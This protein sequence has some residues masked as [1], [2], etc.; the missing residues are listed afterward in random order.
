MPLKRNGTILT[1][2]Q[3]ELQ[4]QE[5]QD[6]WTFQTGVTEIEQTSTDPVATV[7]WAAQFTAPTGIDLPKGEAKD[8]PQV[9]PLTEENIETNRLVDEGLL[10]EEQREDIP[11]I[12][13]QV[14]PV[15]PQ[16]PTTPETTGIEQVDVELDKLRQEKKEEVENLYDSYNISKGQFEKNKQYYTNFDDTNNVFEGV[17]ADIRQ[18]QQAQGNQDL[19]DEQYGQIAQKYGISLEE[20]KNPTQ[21]FQKLEFTDEWK[22]KFGVESAETQIDK[23]Q[24]DFDRAKEDLNT[25]LEVQ[26]ENLENQINDVRDSL[27]RNVAFA[28]AQGVWSGSFRSSGYNQGLENIKEDGQKTISRLQS[29]LERV[30]SANATNL[31]RLTEN[32]NTAVTEAKADLDSQ[33]ETL[34]FDSGLQLSGLSEKY[35]L[36]SDELTKA[37][38]AINEE[39]GTRSLDVYSKYLSNMRDIQT[40]T[41]ENIDRQ[42]ALEEKIREKTDRRYNELLANNGVLLQNTSLNSLMDNVNRGELTVQR[43]NDIK[44]IITSSI[45][46]TLGQYGIVNQADLNTI[47]SLLQQGQTPSQ[48]VAQMQTMDKFKPKAEEEDIIKVKEWET[49]YDPT[50][51]TFTT[52]PTSKE[53]REVKSV[54]EFIK[55]EE[56]FRTEAYLDSAWVPTIGYGFTSVNGVPVKMGDTI[57]QDQAEQ[58]LQRQ[59]ER[60]SNYQALVTVPLSNAQKT[61]LSSFEYNLGPNIWNRDGKEVIDLINSWDLQWAANLMLKFNKARDPE[62][63]ELRVLWWLQNRRNKEANLLL[64]SDAAVSW[65]DEA[66]APLY[67]KFNEGKFTSSDYKNLTVPQD[68][69]IQQANNYVTKLSQEGTWQVQK[70]LGLIQELK[71]VGKIDRWLAAVWGVPFGET[72]DIRASYDALVSNTA[73]NN[74]IEMKAQGAT[75]GA[76]SNQE[77]GFIKDSS[78]KLRLTAS[79]DEWEKELNRM[80]ELL[81]KGLPEWQQQTTQPAQTTQPWRWQK[82]TQNI[83]RWTPNT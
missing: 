81:I 32:Y 34:K 35:G 4:R 44:N 11:Q 30:K 12:Q 36:W 76:L 40:I 79:D 77:L 50:T 70:L 78:T 21:I 22:T 62:T 13:S 63:W 24:T 6:T 55:W 48:V 64:Q 8:L 51:K 26:K 9:E 65:Y 19:T 73:L 14:E 20:A 29:S 60:H 56:W 3:E 39:F 49:L 43:F 38:D 67:K 61:A 83:W 59:I 42:E 82:D 69:F 23:L 71:D 52:I 46:G 31:Q 68:E 57:T 15:Q 18:M 53:Q 2:E 66:L 27:A 5:K 28:E 16:Q 37:L 47:D 74:L 72:S 80:E 45:T 41:N 75:F 7:A 54:T 33:L 10:P 1:P 58:E 17:L 25:N